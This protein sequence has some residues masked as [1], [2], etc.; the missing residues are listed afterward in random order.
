ME[1]KHRKMYPTSL[2]SWKKQIKTLMKSY[3]I[4]NRMANIKKT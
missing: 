4:P 3:C 2:V 1:N